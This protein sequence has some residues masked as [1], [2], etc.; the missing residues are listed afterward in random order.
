M[1]ELA[2]GYGL[3]F[4]VDARTIERV[5]DR[6]ISAHPGETLRLLE[7]GIDQGQTARGIRAWLTEKG[8]PFEY[9]GVESGRTGR[10]VEPFE[11][12]HI[13]VGDSTEVW[14]HVPEGMHFAFIDACHCDNHVI[15]DFFNYHPKVRIGG[16]LLFHDTTPHTSFRDYQL[17]GPHIQEFHINC[18][19]ALTRIGL[20]QGRFRRM[21]PG[22][23]HLARRG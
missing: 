3:L 6:L 14:H 20:I 11:G 19:H 2:K 16:L 23:G 10:A 12:A 8:Q 1:P 4:E 5:L 13:I 18:R 15:L 21:D 22:R 7:V 9:W 17:H